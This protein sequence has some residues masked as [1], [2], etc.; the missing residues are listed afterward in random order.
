MSQSTMPIVR[1]ATERGHVNIDW[2]NSYHTF[3]FGNYQDPNWM[4][5]RTLRV[6]NDDIVAPASGFGTHAHRDMEIVTY[7]L[8]GALEHKDSL[9]TGAVIHPGEVQRMTAGTGITHSEFNHSAEEAVHLLQIWIIPD[10]VGLT[11][12][13]EQKQFPAAEK[14]GKLRLV[15]SK[16]GRDGSVTIHQD[17]DMY[18]GLISTNESISFEPQPDRSLWLHVAQGEISI[19]DRVLSAGDAIAYPPSGSNLTITSPTNAEI[20]L[21]DLK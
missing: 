13:Y 19:D 12:S 6:I 7:V 5:F 2:L 3:S 8:A 16:N 10:T 17:V 1:K 20:I 14:Q 11:P 15:A 4:G 9:G 18:V 21:F